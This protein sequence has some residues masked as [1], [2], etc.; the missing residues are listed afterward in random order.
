MEISV[1][2][3][4]KRRLVIEIDSDH[5]FCNLIKTELWNDKGVTVASYSVDHPLVGKPR[6]II[7]TNTTIEPREALQKAV[8]RLKKQVN[9]FKKEAVKIK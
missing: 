9:D 1:L 8:D 3:E 2:E 4:T 7:E 5:G 6:M